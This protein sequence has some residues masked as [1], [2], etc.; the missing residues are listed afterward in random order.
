MGEP[1]QA[2]SYL[3][4]PFSC[5]RISS[6]LHSIYQNVKDSCNRSYL[7]T[8]YLKELFKKYFLSGQLGRYLGERTN[9]VYWLNC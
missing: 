4:I 6:F 9:I 5:N 8:I 2:I 3:H 7:Q 1:Q